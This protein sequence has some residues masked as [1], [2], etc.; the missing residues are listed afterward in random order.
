MLEL[1]K[2]SLS[3]NLFIFYLSQSF[4]VNVQQLRLL[5][6][7]TTFCYDFVAETAEP[8]IIFKQDIKH[9]Y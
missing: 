3:L 6:M 5:L 8:W 4:H 1:P 2:R 9:F 7:T